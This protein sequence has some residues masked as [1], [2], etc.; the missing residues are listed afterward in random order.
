LGFLANSFDTPLDRGYGY[1]LKGCIKGG[2]QGVYQGRGYIRSGAMMKRAV[3]VTVTAILVILALSFVGAFLLWPNHV[4]ARIDNNDVFK[5]TYQFLLIGVIGGALSLFY[6]SVQ[7]QRE[8]REAENQHKREVREA[9]RGLQRQL[10]RDVIQAY[11]GA[12]KVRRLVRAKARDKS[13]NV[14]AQP[15]DEQM[16]IL[17]DIQLSF[18]AFKHQ[19][20]ANPQLFPPSSGVQAGLDKIEK[21][22]NKIVDEY[23]THLS[24]FTGRPAAT[25]PL[26]QLGALEEF[27]AE[28]RANTDFDKRFKGA[29]HDVVAGLQK[30]IIA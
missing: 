29:F 18:E 20:Q 6:Q 8:V 4:R 3:T 2:H 30:L 24:S 22:L 19:A 21:Y 7:H 14:R 5:L 10:L 28:R 25:L 16:Q 17:L 12:K 13:M 15:Y 1:G 27:I 9:E 26:A 11:N 23:E